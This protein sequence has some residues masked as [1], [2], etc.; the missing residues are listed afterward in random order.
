MLPFVRRAELEELSPPERTKM[1]DRLVAGY[2]EHWPYRTP[3]QRALDFFEAGIM[4]REEAEE[5]CDC[6]KKQFSALLTDRRK[7]RKFQLRQSRR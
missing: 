3:L 5:R 4:D 6:T 2:N 7:E 1:L